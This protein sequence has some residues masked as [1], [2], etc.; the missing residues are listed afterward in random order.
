MHDIS[1]RRPNFRF[2][3]ELPVLF[4]E[5][6]PEQSYGLVGF[7][8]LLPYLEPY[9]IRTMREARGRVRDPELVKDLAAFSAQEGQHYRMHRRFNEALGLRGFPGLQALE[10][11]LEA[12]YQRFTRTKSLRFNLAFAEGF[13]AMTTASAR[14]AFESKQFEKMHPA[15]AD[16]WNWHLVEELEHRTVAF[17]VYAHLYGSYAYRLAVGAYAQWHTLRFIGRVAAYMMRTDVESFERYGGRAGFRARRRTSQKA[18]LRGFVPKLL[19]T[20]LP[21]YTP[22][23]IEFSDQMHEL[24]RRYDGIAAGA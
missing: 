13:E 19:A 23:K 12:D 8:L 16:L 24:A 14:F 7:S 3:E 5:G 21:W 20:Y 15:A 22:E 17:D 6:D 9:L 11:E 2:A 10:D 18:A 4:V 1:V